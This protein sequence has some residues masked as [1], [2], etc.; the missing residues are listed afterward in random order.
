M[1]IR[2]YF[3]GN[4]ALRSGFE[5]FFSELKTAAHEA[6]SALELIAAKDG[7]S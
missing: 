1:E 2:I 7:L 5:I 6:R 3:E 4:K